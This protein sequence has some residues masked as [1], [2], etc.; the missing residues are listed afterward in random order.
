MISV[1]RFGTLFVRINCMLRF[2][3]LL[4]DASFDSK[5]QKLV[6]SRSV[7][8]VIKADKTQKMK[9][10]RL[11]LPAF[12]NSPPRRH[13]RRRCFRYAT[14]Y[15]VALYVDYILHRDWFWAISIASGSVRL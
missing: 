2:Q 9:L 15:C 14:Q 13:L 6:T 7:S 8:H 1:V 12:D 5:Y 4:Y 11:E 3:K 10:K